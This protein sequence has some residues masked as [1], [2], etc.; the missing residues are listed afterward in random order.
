MIAALDAQ[1]DELLH[2]FDQEAWA[3]LPEETRTRLEQDVEC[4]RQRS[5][6]V[7]R[8]SYLTLRERLFVVQA[9]ELG[10]R[11][12]IDFGTQAEDER[13][14]SV[15]NDIAHG[16]PVRSGADVIDAL[17]AAERILDSIR[18]ALGRS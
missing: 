4:A 11:L 16:R 5:E 10:R 2:P 3:V 7:H 9:L 6:E 15:R 13:I 8:L 18:E 1:L 14:V 12:G 17:A